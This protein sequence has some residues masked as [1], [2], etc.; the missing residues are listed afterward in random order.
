M[1]D[2]LIRPAGPPDVPLILAF[3]RELAAYEKL[4]D[5]V[6]ATEEILV[7]WLFKKQ[8]AEALIGELDGQPVGYTL[9]FYNFSTF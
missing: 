6:T 5:Q 9:F 7:E 2:F 1:G 3:I 4:S 8:T